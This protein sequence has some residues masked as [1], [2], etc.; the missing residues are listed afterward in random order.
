MVGFCMGNPR[1]SPPGARPRQRADR[2]GLGRPRPVV[3][4]GNQ[5][6]ALICQASAISFGLRTQA[7]Q[8]ALVVAFGRYLNSLAAPIPR[9]SPR[10][11]P[12]RDQAADP[13]DRPL[14]RRRQRLGRQDSPLGRHRQRGPA[15]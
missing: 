5:G 4:L 7:G 11:L 9:R 3:D 10:L 6:A 13:D 2:P 1:A 8:H 15:S 14:W 12:V